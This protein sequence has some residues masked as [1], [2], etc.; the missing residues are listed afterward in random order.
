[1]DSIKIRIKYILSFLKKDWPLSDYPIKYYANKNAGEAKVRIGAKILNWAGP[2]GFGSSKRNAYNDLLYRFNLQKNYYKVL[3]RPGTIRP[4]QFESQDKIKEYEHI[5]VDFLKEIF[6]LNYNEG[7]YSDGSSL[8]LFAPPN[9]KDFKKHII[10]KVK[11]VYD[12]DITDVYDQ[13]L[14]Q[15]LKRIAEKSE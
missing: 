13:P 5:A 2:G 4:L 3:P 7:F 11:R 8:D 9:S 1:M 14:W 6:N 10:R 15:V 12:I